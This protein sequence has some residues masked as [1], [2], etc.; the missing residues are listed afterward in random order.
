MSL[1]RLGGIKGLPTFYAAKEAMGS[2][3]LILLGISAFC[4]ILTGLIANFVAVSRLIHAMSRDKMAP[5]RL[6]A[7][8]RRGVPAKA[9]V[10]VAAVSCL[11]PLLGR[12]AIGW[13]VDVTTIGA[14]VVYA[15]VSVC[16]LVVGKREKKAAVGIFGAL[17]LL[18]S[19]IFAFS[20]MLPFISPQSELASESYLILLLWSVAGILVFRVLMQRDK[21]RRV[22]QSVIVWIVLFCLV[23]LLSVSWVN[24]TTADK[25]RPKNGN[26]SLL[27][28]RRKA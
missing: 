21:T 19:L 5:K 6:G 12:T 22:G 16:A 7:I 25:A 24:R 17:G 23:L 2:F 1:T 13:I 4:G 28:R 27:G 15:C 3:G 11:I 8:S 9:T 10:C 14:T 20:Y 26:T 18:A